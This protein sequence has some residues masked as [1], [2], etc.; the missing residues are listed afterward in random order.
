M[1]QQELQLS[2]K[3]SQQVMGLQQE[4]HHQKLI[5]E[6]QGNDLALEYHHRKAQDDLMLQ[7]YEMQKQHYDEQMKLYSEMQNNVYAQH[8]HTQNMQM[9]GVGGGSYVPPPQMPAQA[10]AQAL[11]QSH[12]SYVPPP[13][14]TAAGGSYVPP[15]EVCYGQALPQGPSYAVPPTQY[16]GTT[17]ALPG[18]EGQYGGPPTPGAV[19]APT[20]YQAP[21]TQFGGAAGGMGMYQQ[22]P[23]Q[24]APTAPNI[25]GDA[26]AQGGYEAPATAYPNY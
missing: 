5:L 9:G 12:P 19:V 14:Q 23:Y 20:Q 22:S 16:A 18:V 21:P 24:A 7:Q 2:Q 6:K 1:G 3:Y 17:Q 25:Y 13:S 15:P 4:Y 11:Q 26:A 8:M 10:A